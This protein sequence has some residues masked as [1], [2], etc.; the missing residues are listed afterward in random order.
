M[1]SAE[2]GE[3]RSVAD[4]R[5][6][7]K[8]DQ[9]YTKDDANAK[10]QFDEGADEVKAEEENQ[11]SGDGSEESAVLE[12]EGADSAGRRSE[13]NEHHRKAGDK[14]E[15]RGEKAGGWYVPFAELLHADAGEHGDVARHQ[16]Q[17]A[18]REEGNQPREEGPC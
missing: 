15:R 14:G 17:N 1:S 8:S 18:R 7:A 6:Y 16:R 4:E 5:N 11:G 9:E 3:E 12:K 13:G 2:S 10:I